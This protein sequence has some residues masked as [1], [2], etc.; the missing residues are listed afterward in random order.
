[1][2]SI[3]HEKGVKDL[4]VDLPKKEVWI[5]F[6]T[7]KTDKVKLQKAI[8]K[9]GY[10]VTEVIPEAKEQKQAPACKHSESCSKKEAACCKKTEKKSE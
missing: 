3:P 6:D 10:T 2:N 1:M 5:K 8:E 9:L 4:K 7:Q